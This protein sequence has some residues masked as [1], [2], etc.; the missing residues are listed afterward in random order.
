MAD[1]NK[2][3]TGQR[4]FEITK[5]ME[6]IGRWN[7]SVTQLA[8]K[9]GVARL[10]I[11]KDLKKICARIPQEEIDYMAYDLGICYKKSFKELMRILATSKSERNKI[12]AAGQLDNLAKGMIQLLESFGYKEKVAEKIQVETN[13]FEELSDELQSMQGNLITSGDSNK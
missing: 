9:Y 6:N 13:L 4:R 7:L 12:V 5:L 11:Y 1:N 2:V 8:A 10:T 3:T